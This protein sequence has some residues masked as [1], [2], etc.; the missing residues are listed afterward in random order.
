MLVGDGPWR[1]GCKPAIPEIVFPGMR[2]GAD[3]AAHYASADLF[4]FPSLTETFGNVTWKRW[5]AG[6]RWWPFDYAAA[7]RHIV[8]DQSGLLAPCDDS[9]P[10]HRSRRVGW[11]ATPRSVGPWGRAARQAVLAFDW[12]RIYQTVGAMVFGVGPRGPNPMNRVHEAM[13]LRRLAELDLAWC[14]RFPTGPA[15]AV[16]LERLFAVVSRLGDGVFWYTLMLAL[17]FVLGETALAGGGT[18]AGGWDIGAGAVQVAGNLAPPACGLRRHDHIRASVAPL[19]E[20]S[21][22]SVIL[23]TRCRSAS[24]RFALYPAL[25]WLVVPFT[26]LVALSRVVLGLH[27]P[28]SDVPGRALLGSGL[29]TL[30]LQF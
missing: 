4:L 7:H 2:I 8:H 18:D 1:R 12:E 29:A 23:C 16:N 10:V 15:S 9:Q 20:Y 11:P 21:F 22:P 6:W 19:D 13:P 27:Y 26:V 30:V 17:L 14:L 25:A 28:K 24:W 5:P 3:L